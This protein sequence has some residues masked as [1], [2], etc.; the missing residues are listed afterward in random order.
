MDTLP[1][2][3]ELQI[4]VHPSAVAVF[5]APSDLCGTQGLSSERIRAVSS[6]QG[7]AGRYDCIFVET[8]PIALGML[9][10]DVAQVK[11]FLSFTYGSRVYNCALVSW[12]SRLGEK[13]DETTRM[14]MLEAAYDDEDHEDDN[15]DNEKQRYNSIISM[16]SVV[17]AAHLIPIFGNAKFLPRGLT[18]N[19]TLTTIFRGWYVNKYIDYHAFEIAF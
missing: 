10:L 8:D 3:S 7:G 6:W 9:G 18:P 11:A 12:F 2:V 19:H 15:R 5:H 13:P 14:W 4:S 1:D 16:D 17:R